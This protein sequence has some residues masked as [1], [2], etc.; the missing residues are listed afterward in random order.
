MFRSRGILF[1]FLLSWYIF[2]IIPKQIHNS[3]TLFQFSPSKRPNLEPVLCIKLV[4]SIFYLIDT[5]GCNQSSRAQDV[6]STVQEKGL[7]FVWPE[8]CAN[9]ATWS[10]TYSY[11]KIEIIISILPWHC[12]ERVLHG[13]QGRRSRD[14]R[15]VVLVGLH[16]SARCRVS[17]K[18][19]QHRHSYRWPGMRLLCVGTTR[20]VHQLHS[21]LY[22]QKM[23]RTF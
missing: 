6:T 14:N 23:W 20:I 11:L 1:N 10:I 12:E 21:L 15:S 19:L 22:R 8:Y 13:G 16:G 7:W 3:F 2:Y 17:K 18:M 9:I 5:T 4:W